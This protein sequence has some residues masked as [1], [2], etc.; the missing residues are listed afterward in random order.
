MIK[1]KESLLRVS[2]EFLRWLFSIGFFFLAITKARL[3]I[4][5]GLE[6]YIEIVAV[7]GLPLYFRHYSILAI[8]I[9][10]YLAIWLWD[11]KTYKSA[12]LLAGFLTTIGII[13]SLSFIYF[14]INSD[15]GCGLLGG[16]EY[17]LL[18][19]KIL[20]M[21]GLMILYKN[22]RILFVDKQEAENSQMQS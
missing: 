11:N 2:V 3:I 9:E 22:E 20:I 5:F 18:A 4:L 19:Q 13:I 21:L 16:S 1:H 14:K 8:I 7:L 17:G 10:L 15:C 6:P 12:L